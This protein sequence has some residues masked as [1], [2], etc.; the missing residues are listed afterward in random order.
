MRFI[1]KKDFFLRRYVT[2]KKFCSGIDIRPKNIY[3]GITK[4]VADT[5]FTCLLSRQYDFILKSGL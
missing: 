5:V 4:G 2:L 3:T 1:T